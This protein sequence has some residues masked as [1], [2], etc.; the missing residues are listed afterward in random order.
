MFDFTA[1]ISSFDSTGSSTSAS[2]QSQAFILEQNC[3]CR[4]IKLDKP[5]SR[6]ASD[7][8]SKDLFYDAVE[9]ISLPELEPSVTLKALRARQFL[10]RH[11]YLA[12]Q[13]TDYSTSFRNNWE[14]LKH[15]YSFLYIMATL[16]EERENEEDWPKGWESDSAFIFF[17]RFTVASWMRGLSDR[18]KVDIEKL[19]NVMGGFLSIDPN[20]QAAIDSYERRV[21]ACVN[22]LYPVAEAKLKTE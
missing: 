11:Q 9:S 5:E 10:K 2:S 7:G 18:E 1:S 4:T 3:K 20:D 16:T 19:A 6:L 14:A 15:S 21:R 8:Q 22:D 17:F 12:K 13:S